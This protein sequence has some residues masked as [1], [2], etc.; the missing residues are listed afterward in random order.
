LNPADIVHVYPHLATAPGHVASK[1][2]ADSSSAASAHTASAHATTNNRPACVAHVPGNAAFGGGLTQEWRA[3]LFT[4]Y[5]G[6]THATGLAT[7]RDDTSSLHCIFNNAAAI[8]CYTFN[9]YTFATATES[10]TSRRMDL[11]SDLS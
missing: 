11:I 5:A 10:T 4:L 7:E 1:F 8:S 2:T 6:T 9:T 3:S